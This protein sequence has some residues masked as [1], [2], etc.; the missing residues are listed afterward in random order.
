M[1]TSRNSIRIHMDNMCDRVTQI[2]QFYDS[3][4][5][6]KRTHILGILGY[7]GNSTIIY[8]NPF[9]LGFVSLPEFVRTQGTLT[10]DQIKT[11]VHSLLLAVDCC[12]EV[13]HGSVDNRN[14]L[15]RQSGGRLH[16]KIGPF[17]K[18]TTL[19]NDLISVGSIARWLGSQQIADII[20]R[21]LDACVSRN[22]IRTILE[23]PELS[24]PGIPHFPVVDFT[25]FS[26][27]LSRFTGLLIPQPELKCTIEPAQK[28]SRDPENLQASESTDSL[29][30]ATFK[31][32]WS[33]FS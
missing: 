18:P 22:C 29:F 25:T 21:N 24:D 30:S 28:P 16:V 10:S 19:E 5:E 12:K 2:R 7:D 20:V 23:N 15:I 6:P 9:I 27:E 14:V 33:K 26:S 8:T 11:I 17:G 4:D 31:Y 32:I 3:L 1:I 13:S